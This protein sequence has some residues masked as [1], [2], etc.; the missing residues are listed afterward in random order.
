MKIID[1]A[2]VVCSG[3]GKQGSI[4][5]WKLRGRRRRAR[6]LTL[7]EM[8]VVIFTLILLAVIL[9]TGASAWKRGSDRAGCILNLQAVQKAVRS[10]GNMKGLTAGDSV[11][12]LE[13]EVIGSGRFFEAL[14]DCPGGGNYTLGGNQLPPVGT[15]YM[16]CSLSASELHEPP[17]PGS[18]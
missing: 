11:T 8:T 18:W 10:Y 5:Y 6:G 3:S 7:V 17:N 1:F 14:P 16:N 13:T 2:G 12:G 15:L 4:T 9:L